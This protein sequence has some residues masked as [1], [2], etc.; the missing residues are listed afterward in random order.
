MAT[1]TVHGTDGTPGLPGMTMTGSRWAKAGDAVAASS[2]TAG[3]RRMNDL[4]WRKFADTVR[5]SQGKFV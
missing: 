2:K 5:K 3:T 4:K 1:E